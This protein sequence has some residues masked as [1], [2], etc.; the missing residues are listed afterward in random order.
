MKSAY[1]IAAISAAVAAAAGAQ[2][3]PTT[4]APVSV[5][6]ATTLTVTGGD[7]TIGYSGPASN[8]GTGNALNAT[9]NGTGINID[10]F[11]YDVSNPSLSSSTAL[12][13][14]LGDGT[15]GSVTHSTTV[16]VV[17]LNLGGAA[18]A[19]LARTWV[20][21]AGG[22]QTAALYVAADGN[23]INGVAISSDQSK[24][25]AGDL[26]YAVSILT[27]AASDN[28]GVIPGYNQSAGG[29]GLTA[30]I[31]GSVG[32]SVWYSTMGLELA[33]ANVDALD[34]LYGASN[35]VTTGGTP[36]YAGSQTLLNFQSYITAAKA[37]ADTAAAAPNAA[38]AVI[39]VPSASWQ[40]NQ[41]LTLVGVAA[42]SAGGA[43]QI[44]ITSIA[45]GAPEPS[46]WSLTIGGLG[47]L[48]AGLRRRA[49]RLTV[50]A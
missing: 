39:A 26:E 28:G 36:A 25:L 27:K 45:S 2:A 48:G 11:L 9:L 47:L 15:L 23:T 32:S 10:P 35:V 43:A 17:G 50:E 21:G 6:G 49:R 5:G 3:A 14:N 40:P 30:N 8:G 31:Q 4:A 33:A 44:G 19:S 29:A 24:H 41:P 20:T 42:N 46:T 37:Y 7:R 38:F 1:L 13:A 16:Q 12:T 18:P 22:T 34:T